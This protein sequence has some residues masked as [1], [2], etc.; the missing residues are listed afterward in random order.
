MNR[1]FF[2]TIALILSFTLFVGCNDAGKAKIVDDKGAQSAFDLVNAR[3][4]VDSA[5]HE[6]MDLV[7]KGDSVALANHYTIDAKLMQ[8]NQPPAVGRKDIQTAIANL[9][10]AGIKLNLTTV[11]L[12]GDESI[13]AEEGTVIVETKDGK[14]LDKGKY[15]VL[16]KKEDGKW[17]LFRDFFNSDLPAPTAK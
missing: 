10:S 9:V 2:S 8:P 3:K 15:V 14:Q 13:L 11:D 7:S 5:N 16:W 1:I 4:Q 12:W 6:F 17:K